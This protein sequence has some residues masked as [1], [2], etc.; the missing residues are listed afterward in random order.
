MKELQKVSSRQLFDTWKNVSLSIFIIIGVVIACRLFP[1]YFSPIIGLIGSSVLFTILYQNKARGGSACMILPYSLFF[2][3]IA[4]S[5]VSIT[6]NV[7]YIWGWMKLPD[8]FIFFNDPYIPTLWLNPICFLTLL[9]INLRRR[10]L[11]LCIECRMRNGTHA[12]RGVFGSVINS[13]SKFQLR[14]L[15]YVFLA[16]SIFIWVYYLVEYNDIN[17]NGR[18]LYMFFWSTVLVLAIDILYFTFR[19]Y[20]LYLD[21]KENN[22]IVTDEELDD[23][24]YQSYY[25]FY[26]ICG[27]N[28]YL[29]Q[30]I[31]SLDNPLQGIDTPFIVKRPS[32]MLSLPEVKRI[33][34]EMAGAEGELKF[35]FGRRSADIDKYSLLRYFYFLDGG[36]DNYPILG[37]E[38]EWMDF[39]IIKQ[40][41]SKTPA[42]FS[43]FAL[44][45]LTRLA[46]IMVTQK[47]FNE[48]GFRKIKLKS[49]NP[50][51]DL[52]EVRNSTLDFQDDKWIRI[53]RFNSDTKFYRLKRW[54]RNI[55]LNKA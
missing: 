26:V 36:I 35:F 25:R 37:K 29:S 11:R 55:N 23:M 9:I 16:L 6:A 44:T 1:F 40:I 48:R 20:N 19:Y 8:E 33:I 12:E 15:L 38:G 53:S 31:D 34:K 4:F 7:M 41:Y 21:L 49:Y 10:K 24:S 18:D 5:F 39:N 32:G 3:L 2:C 28:V 22:E 54:F 17:T 46:T 14:N 51:F 30:N 27:N 47:L 43:N 45:D 50:S 13:E 52:E 42:V